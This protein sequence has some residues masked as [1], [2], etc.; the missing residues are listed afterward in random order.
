MAVAALGRP[1]GGRRAG[2]TGC[3]GARRA[4]CRL[5][6]VGVPRRPVDAD[7]GPSRLGSPPPRPSMRS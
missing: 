5:P 6:A 4:V 3:G 1:T 2:R 7:N